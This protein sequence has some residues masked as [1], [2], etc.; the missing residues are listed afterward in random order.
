MKKVILS[1]SLIAT[2]LATNAMA[3]NIPNESIPG[4]NKQARNNNMTSSA[5]TSDQQENTQ[6]ALQAIMNA[7][8]DGL[9]FDSMEQVNNFF[10][11][12]GLDVKKI[13]I[14]T[15]SQDDVRIDFSNLTLTEDRHA[16]LTTAQ[17]VKAVKA[18]QSANPGI[19][20]VFFYKA[21]QE[22]AKKFAKALNLTDKS[23]QKD[24]K[25]NVKVMLNKR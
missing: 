15:I 18:L 19:K 8:A 1:F 23:M 7:G 17:V 10:Q 5:M 12:S 22:D 16:D 24:A 11:Q 21:H 4:A 14:T 9:D 13:T 25:G 20:A 2:L 6:N 3:A